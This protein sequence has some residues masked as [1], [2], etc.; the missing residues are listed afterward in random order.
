M[1]VVSTMEKF[2]KIINKR[3][4]RLFLVVWPPF[5]EE[6]EKQIDISIGLVFSDAEHQLCVISTELDDLTTPCIRYQ[7]VPDVILSWDSFETRMKSWMDATEEWVIDTEYYEV[8]NVEEFKDIV[9][10]T[11]LDVELVGIQ[12]EATP[13]G[14]KLLF[15]NDYIL[16]TPIIDGNTIE[17]S[18]FN[19]NANVLNFASLGEIVYTSMKQ[20]AG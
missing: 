4:D 12:N 15:N 2:K 18:H 5:A 19:K 7:T 10:Q 13:F 9:R 16:S 20:L 6:D 3:V 11:I 14:V 8:T 1:A 17:T